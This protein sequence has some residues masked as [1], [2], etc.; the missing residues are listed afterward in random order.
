M[1][2]KEKEVKQE[3]DKISKVEIAKVV[4]SEMIA[5]MYREG[6]DSSNETVAQFLTEEREVDLMNMEVVDRVL[7]VYAPEIKKIERERNGKK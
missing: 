7:S 2:K 3:L 6:Y 5:S 1:E 4:L